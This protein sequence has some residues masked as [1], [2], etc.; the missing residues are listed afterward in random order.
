MLDFG[1]A[2]SVECASS[3]TQSEFVSSSIGVGTISALSFSECSEGCT[4]QA[5]GLPYQGWYESVSG[6]EADLRILKLSGQVTLGVKCKTAECVY[7]TAEI[8]ARFEGGEPGFV[9]VVSSLAEKEES[10]FCPATMTWEAFYQITS[11]SS[12]YAAYRGVEGPAFCKVNVEK[13]PQ[14]SI[15][16]EVSNEMFVPQM[17][18]GTFVGGGTITCAE[19]F[20]LIVDEELEATGPWRYKPASFSK[21][22]S[23]TYSAGEVHFK[24]DPYNAQLTPIGGGEGSIGVSAGPGGGEPRLEVSCTYLKTPYTC[25]YKTAEFFLG[26]QAGAPPFTT[27][28]GKYEKVEGSASF[29]STKVAL[30][31]KYLSTTLSGKALYLTEAEA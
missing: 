23:A 27:E 18:L 24:N 19:G 10:F 29:C 25:L 5:D 13:C 12:L 1:A 8:G 28:S 9:T 22:T 31:A 3:L 21:C 4:V 20:F 30:T 17:T 2:G 26:F 6:G 14:E 16:T 11:P 15:V 7:T